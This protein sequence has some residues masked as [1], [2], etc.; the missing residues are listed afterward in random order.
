MIYSRCAEKVDKCNRSWSLLRTTNRVFKVRRQPLPFPSFYRPLLEAVD[1]LS[2][3]AYRT[4]VAK[5]RR[6]SLQSWLIRGI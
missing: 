4:L 1:F 5:I 3:L 6:R 2:I